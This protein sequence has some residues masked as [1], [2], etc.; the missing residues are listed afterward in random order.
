MTSPPLTAPA[1][2]EFGAADDAVFLALAAS[3]SRVGIA[4]YALGAMLLVAG[5]LSVVRPPAHLPPHAAP[6]IAAI[7]LLGVIPAAL[8]ARQLREAALSLRAVALTAGDDVAHFMAAVESLKRAL[9]MVV[10]MLALDAA[11]LA[12]VV[13]VMFPRGG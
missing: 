10:A 8:S 11:G 6:V 4:G 2:H 7:T 9:T 5:V 13:A 12:V 3:A 1:S